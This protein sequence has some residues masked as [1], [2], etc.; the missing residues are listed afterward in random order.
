MTNLPLT[1][2][3]TVLQQIVTFNMNITVSLKVYTPY[4]CGKM[5]KKCPLTAIDIFEN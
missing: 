1:Q 5:K 3:S 4:I 2:N